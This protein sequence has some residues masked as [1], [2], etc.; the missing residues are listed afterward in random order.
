M[1]CVMAIVY[2]SRTTVFV[3][4]YISHQSLPTLHSPLPA[5]TNNTATT[6]GDDAAHVGADRWMGRQRGDL[7][8]PDGA[9][10]PRPLTDDVAIDPPS[11][12]SPAYF[13]VLQFHTFQ[14]V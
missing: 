13:Q 7:R 2:T 12:A 5:I 6:P 8:L 9:V 14:P 3:E 1:R 4:T 10:C 11:G